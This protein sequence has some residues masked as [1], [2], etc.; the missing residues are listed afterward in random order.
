MQN[1]GFD[2]SQWHLGFPVAVDDSASFMTVDSS[3][4]NT[5]VMPETNV[6]NYTVTGAMQKV[7][8]ASYESTLLDG[9]LLNLHHR[10]GH[11]SEYQRAIFV[12]PRVSTDRSK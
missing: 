2:L 5:I 8:A 4:T 1:H 6:K 7:H 9:I 3:C 12:S 11:L 10:R